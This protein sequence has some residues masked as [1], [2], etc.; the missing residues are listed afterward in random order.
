MDITCPTCRDA[1][2]PVTRSNPFFPFCCRA[3]KDR[4]LS[5]WVE[6]KYRVEGKPIADQEGDL[7]EPTLDDDEFGEDV[8]GDV[9]IDWDG[10]G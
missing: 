1:S 5:N 3:C 8:D 7:G 6:E 9:E 2:K 4:D 10:V